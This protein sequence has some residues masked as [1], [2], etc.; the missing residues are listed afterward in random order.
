MLGI[1]GTCCVRLY[2]PLNGGGEGGGR[3]G[4]RIFL[5]FYEGFLRFF[6]C[7]FSSCYLLGICF[8][9]Y[10]NICNFLKINRSTSI[11]QL[12]KVGFH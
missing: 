9:F 10:Q 2:G 1:V 4:G 8:K 5:I 12:I 6:Q 7:L 3:R 11:T